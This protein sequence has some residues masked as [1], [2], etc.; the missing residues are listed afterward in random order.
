MEINET[1]LR[2]TKSVLL[3]A[4]RDILRPVITELVVLELF[5]GSGRVSLA[6]LEEGAAR[7]YCVDL[8]ESP[9]QDERIKWYRQDVETFLNYGPPEEVGLVFMDP[10]YDMGYPLR[11][12]KKLAAS[13][14][15]KKEAIIAVETRSGVEE[16]PPVVEDKFYLMRR[17]RYGGSMLWIYQ[18]DREK[19]V[20]EELPEET[21]DVE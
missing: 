19:P 13:S 6:L 1:P 16:L 11:L 8:R 15:L 3:K 5:A 4:L 2:K 17:R 14:W 21:V 12:L 9:L 18:A 20:E 10:P 7:S